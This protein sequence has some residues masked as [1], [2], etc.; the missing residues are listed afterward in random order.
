MTTLRSRAAEDLAVRMLARG[1][2]DKL[3]Q[4]HTLLSAYV[5]RDI[6][7]REC[8]GIP[9][10]PGPVPYT[11][12]R[13]NE[14]LFAQMHRSL[15]AVLYRRTIAGHIHAKTDIE[16]LI[17]AYDLYCDLADPPLFVTFDEAWLIARELRGGSM[18]LVHCAVCAV[19]YLAHVQASCPFCAAYERTTGF[20]K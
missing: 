12:G 1:A 7:N 13:D 10:K 8:G 18:E 6:R 15:V 20:L 5:V 16:S 9:A 17:Q 19:D 14:S 4:A 2:R 3:V 11:V